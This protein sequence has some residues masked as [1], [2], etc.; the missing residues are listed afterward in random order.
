MAD[1]DEALRRK[2]GGNAPPDDAF[3]RLVR[4]RS[5]RQRNGRIGAG[6]VALV[7]AAAGAGFAWMSFDGGGRGHP[8]ASPPVHPSPTSS[9]VVG[10]VVPWDQVPPPP[11][12]FGFDLTTWAGQGVARVVFA[13]GGH[14]GPSQA[15]DALTAYTT[16]LKTQGWVVSWEASVAQ[17]GGLGDPEC[18]GGGRAFAKG[19][20]RLWAFSGGCPH[21]LRFTVF[22]G[23]LRVRRLYQCGT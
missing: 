20:V 4:E 23:P 22:R 7:V 9:A 8:A 3:E 2:L 6:A 14:H 16:T 21:Q 13:D 1:V 17:H 10:V 11:D 19:G 5:R 12:G 18:Y 15:T